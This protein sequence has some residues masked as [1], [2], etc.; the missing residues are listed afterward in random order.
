M[1]NDKETFDIFVKADF[2]DKGDQ[3]VEKVKK[4]IDALYTQGEFIMNAGIAY[5]AIADLLDDSLATIEGAA[6]RMAGCWGDKGSVEAQKALQSLHFTIGEVVTKSKAMGGPLEH[7]GRTILPQA[8]KYGDW[9]TGDDGAFGTGFLGGSWNDDLPGITGWTTETENEGATKALKALNEALESAHN[10]LPKNV[11]MDLFKDPNG[12]VPPPPPYTPPKGPGVVPTNFKPPGGD[13]PG[14]NPDN[15]G[16]DIPGL[17]PPGGIP[18][19]KGPDGNYPPGYDPNNP[20]G[21]GNGNGNGTGNGN[22]NGNGPGN[23]PIPKYPNGTDVPAYN[24]NSGNPPNTTPAYN[25]DAGPNGTKLAD[26]QPANYNPVTSPTTTGSPYPTGV[27][28]GP[29]TGAGTGI[30]AGGLS[31]VPG[32][33]GAGAAGLNGSGMPMMP[34]TG[35]GAGGNEERDRESTTWLLEDEDVWGGNDDGIVNNQIG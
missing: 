21:N 9:A 35:A 20:G 30:G 17:N 26:F 32:G 4:I 18:P 8:H 7:I 1:A 33:P 15:P 5:K 19:Y 23:S 27:P 3:K 25:P 11:T 31:G 16:G 10:Q 24:P 2:S 14:Y 6:T 29:G 12:S 13:L 34:M 28:G 22:G